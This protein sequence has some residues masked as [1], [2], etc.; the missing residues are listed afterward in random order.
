MFAEVRMT[1]DA[2]HIVLDASRKTRINHRSHFSWQVQ[3]L[4]N[5]DEFR[6]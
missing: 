6:G 1:P 3:Y 2:P 4:V 5:F